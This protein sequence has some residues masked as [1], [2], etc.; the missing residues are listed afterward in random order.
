MPIH[1]MTKNPTV[2][3][4][5]F[6]AYALNALDAPLKGLKDSNSQNGQMCSKDRR[7]MK[8]RRAVWLG[9]LG[10]WKS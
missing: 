5:N 7:D 1:A 8:A 6:L 10:G 4:S 2:M 3:H 9:G